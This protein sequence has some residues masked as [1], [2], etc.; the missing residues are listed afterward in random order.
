MVAG[1]MSGM[2]TGPLPC[3]KL[4][5]DLWLISNEAHAPANLG[6]LDP[7]LIPGCAR[8]RIRPRPALR[9]AKPPKLNGFLEGRA[10]SAEFEVI[11]SIH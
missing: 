11:D 3:Q 6:G 1:K 5:L 9:S 7:I 10:A 2:A 4:S 8:G